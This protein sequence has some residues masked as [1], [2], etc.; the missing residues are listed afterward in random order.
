MNSI[1]FISAILAGTAVGAALGILFAP[2]KGTAYKQMQRRK[3]TDLTKELKDKTNDFIEGIVEKF[4]SAKE[5]AQQLAENGKLTA[6]QLKATL[7]TNQ[8]A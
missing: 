2:G 6:E 5:E 8:K 1:K 4:E 3:G 7:H